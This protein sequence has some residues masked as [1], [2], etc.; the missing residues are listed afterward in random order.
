MNSAL[1]EYIGERPDYCAEHIDNEPDSIYTKCNIF[2]EKTTAGTVKCK[3]LVLK[4]FGFCYKHFDHFLKRFTDL[5]HYSYLFERLIFI[6]TQ[7]KN[8]LEE[9]GTATS[10]EKYLYQRKYK[11]ISKTESMKAQTKQKLQDFSRKLNSLMEK[12]GIDQVVVDYGTGQT[13]QGYLQTNRLPNPQDFMSIYG[14]LLSFQRT[15]RISPGSLFQLPKPDQPQPTFCDF[16][17]ESPATHVNSQESSERAN[18]NRWPLTRSLGET[19]QSSFEAFHSPFYSPVASPS[20]TGNNFSTTM[21]L[22]STPNQAMSYRS[23]PIYSSSS[24][25]DSSPVDSPR[26]PQ[27]SLGMNSSNRMRVHNLL[28]GTK[29]ECQFLCEQDQDFYEN[30]SSRTESLLLWEQMRK[31]QLDPSETETEGNYGDFPDQRDSRLSVSRSSLFHLLNPPE[32]ETRPFFMGTVQT[33]PKHS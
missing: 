19:D 1:M 17:M 13:V 30:L 15:G 16:V 27:E 12:H 21:S 4:D 2:Y 33:Q 29:P 26:S 32:T 9:A 23:H 10:A 7:L 25:S 11:L 20:L 14:M 22:P 5:H 6:E 31:V 3:E 18:P 28:V 24:S 8:L